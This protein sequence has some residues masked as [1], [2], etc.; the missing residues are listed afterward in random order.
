MKTNERLS[1]LA[2]IMVAFGGLGALLVVVLRVWIVPA[3]RDMDTGLFTSNMLVI[4]LMLVLLAA[5]GAVMFLMRDHSRREITG[6]SVYGVADRG[7]CHVAPR[8]GGAVGS[9]R[10]GHLLFGGTTVDR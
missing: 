2:R 5:M 7:R 4:G 9:F 10:Y 8:R 3:Q 1:S 6:N